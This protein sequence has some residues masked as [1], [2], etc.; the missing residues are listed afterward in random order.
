MVYVKYTLTLALV[1][2]V[3]TH[4]DVRTI[5]YIYSNLALIYI[6]DMMQIFGKIMWPSAYWISFPPW[7]SFPL[8]YIV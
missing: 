3:L 5:C 1:A 2:V 7:P 4:N 6:A 8:I